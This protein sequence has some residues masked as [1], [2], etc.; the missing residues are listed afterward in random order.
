MIP[1]KTGPTMTDMLDILLVEDEPSILALFCEALR[2]RGH[3]ITTA[4]D[5]LS[6]LALVDS[7]VFDVV[8]SDVRLPRVNGLDLFHRAR[9]VTPRSRFIVM[10]AYGRVEDAV[11]LMKEGAFDYLTKPVDLSELLQSL[12]RVERE[13]QLDRR[14]EKVRRETRT[15]QKLLSRSPQMT[16]VLE[17][18]ARFGP[19]SDPVLLQG[20]S[21]TGKELIARELHRLSPRAAQPFVVISCAALHEGAVEAEVLELTKGSAARGETGVTLYLKD[22]AEL[23]P[24]AQTKLLR[25][26]EEL[27][28]GGDAGHPRVVSATHRQLR[29][30]V[31]EG[32]FR[33]DL[34]FRLKVLEVTVPP[35]RERGGDLLLL[36]DHFLRRFGGPT[37]PEVSARALAALTQYTF[38]GNVRELEHAVRHAV[39]L[40]GGAE[41]DLASLPEE[42]AGPASAYPRLPPRSLPEAVREF[43]R[44]YLRRAMLRSTGGRAT[45]AESLGISRKNLWEK[46]RG[47]G[48]AAEIEPTP[49]QTPPDGHH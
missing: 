29:T 20:E 12:E 39:T 49:S 46:L 11:N 21:G 6:A 15:D 27:G 41:I 30:Q 22:V 26:M 16:R 4:T 31:S 28:D 23:T 48:L 13:L 25:L 2:S 7:R 43:E 37:T 35:L 5:G 19:S 44:E 10:T 3:R 47:Y 24:A 40:S 18:I 36:L 14:F 34:Y 32:R 33:E 9:V 45:V 8:I 42:I 1:R 38:P 17:Q